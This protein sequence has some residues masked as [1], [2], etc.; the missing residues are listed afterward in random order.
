MKNQVS[1]LTFIVVIEIE[2]VASIAV[3]N[4]IQFISRCT[5]GK[6]VAMRA[7]VSQSVSQS[8][9]IALCACPLIPNFP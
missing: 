8:V 4:L 9:A 2:S 1:P 7:M 6:L 3:S 5:W